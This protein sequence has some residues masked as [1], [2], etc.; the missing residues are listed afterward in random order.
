V[1]VRSLAELRSAVGRPPAGESLVFQV[2][3]RGR[4]LYIVVDLE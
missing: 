4:L 1:S 2:E 3:R